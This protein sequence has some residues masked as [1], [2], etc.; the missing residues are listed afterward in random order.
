MVVL[1]VGFGLLRFTGQGLLTLSS[2]TMIS[3]WFDRRRGVVTSLSIRDLRFWAVTAPIV[4]MS[5]TTT[6]LT[7]HIIDFGAEVGMTA[8]GVVRI[9]V[10]IALVSVR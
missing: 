10:P 6:A 1:S 7:F 5:A 3:Q 9:F 2:R 8:D 4:A